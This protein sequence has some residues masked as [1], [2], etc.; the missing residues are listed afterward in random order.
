MI[1]TIS[2]RETRDYIGGIRHVHFPDTHGTIGVGIDALTESREF[3][4][5]DRF[6]AGDAGGLEEWVQGFATETVEVVGD[7][8]EAG[9]TG[10]KLRGVEGV[11]VADSGGGKNG[12][13]EVAGWVVDVDSVVRYCVSESK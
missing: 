7:G 11:F 6:E 4:L 3:G 2:Q 13:I 8:S 9:E 10:A 1:P 12:T 5:D